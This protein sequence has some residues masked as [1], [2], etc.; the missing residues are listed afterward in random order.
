MM[1]KT[2]ESLLRGTE[3][4]ALSESVRNS[5]PSERYLGRREHGMREAWPPE[6][7]GEGLSTKS[8]SVLRGCHQFEG[9]AT[10]EFIEL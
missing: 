10:L 5:T 4:K 7:L 9:E 6:K 8:T 2:P 1:F 3:K